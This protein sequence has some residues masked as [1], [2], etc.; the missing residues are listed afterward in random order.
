MS[1][2]WRSMFKTYYTYKTYLKLLNSSFSPAALFVKNRDRI[3]TA[4]NRDFSSCKPFFKDE[5]NESYISDINDNDSQK[6]EDLMTRI[7]HMPELGHQMQESEERDYLETRLFHIPEM[8]HQVFV[9]QPYVKW[10]SNKKRNTVPDLQLAESV[11]LIGT[12]RNWKVVDKIK[13]SLTSFEK[14]TFFG[15]GNLKMLKDKIQ[16]NKQITAV[17]LST[18]MLQGIQHR[19]LEQEFGVPVYDRYMIVIQIFREHA[20]SKEAKLQVALAEIPYLRM[21]I[22]GICEGGEDHHGAGIAA[23]GGAGETHSEI[24]KRILFT[25]EMK[26][27]KMLQ[28]VRNQRLLLRNQRKK[29]EFPVVA[30]I[31]YTNA[32]K[33]SLIKA[34]TGEKSLIPKNHLFATLDVTTHAGVLPC[35][36]EVL[37]IDTVGFISDIPTYLI[38]SFMATLEDALNADIIIH[39]CDVGHPDYVAQAETVNKILQ[40][41]NLSSDLLE[42]ILVVGNKVDLL[43]D[44]D[45]GD[46]N[47]DC[48]VL[49]SSVTNEGLSELEKKIEKL[50]LEATGRISIKIR[51]PMDGEE[52]KWLYKHAV[53]TKVLT[54]SENSQHLVLTVIITEAQLNI[55]KHIFIKKK[56]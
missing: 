37:Y 46:R 28:K 32:G 29:L 11:A 25:R 14:K 18:N 44:N 22:K 26:L 38:E 42:K 39:V 24:R 35:N 48:S 50:V 41:L 34:L 43:P 10:G 15:T 55:F 23:I 47:K 7:S 9:I 2:M 45:S 4:V 5:S 19:E 27:K 21:R 3:L 12:L 54:D 40:A 56:S 6:Y 13:I 51:V 1:L 31:G 20:V 30:V 36:L 17:F 52:M 8:G 49:V 53:V 33:T 16:M